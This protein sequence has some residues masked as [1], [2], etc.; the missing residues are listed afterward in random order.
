LRRIVALLY[1]ATLI[2]SGI[3][4]S[5]G[6]PM[7]ANYQFPFLFLSG[8]AD[9]DRD[10]DVADLGTLATNWQQSP[11]TF[12]QGDFDYSGTVDVND[13]VILASHW[14]MTL[15]PSAPAMMGGGRTT[16]RLIDQVFAS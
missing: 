16:S 14:Q 10:V 15:A 6:T 1:R 2:A 5:G 9:N 4:N 7:A 8:D 13:L 3:T 12:A 11:R